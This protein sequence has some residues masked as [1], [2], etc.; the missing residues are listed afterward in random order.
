MGGNRLSVVTNNNDGIINRSVVRDNRI[1]DGCNRYSAYFDRSSVGIDRSSG[2]IIIVAVG[3][4]RS[5]VGICKRCCKGPVGSV[6]GW[7]WSTGERE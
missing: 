5:S 3:I 2:G 7:K 1:F 4:N 6:C